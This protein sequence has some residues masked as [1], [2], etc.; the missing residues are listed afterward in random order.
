MGNKSN[1]KGKKRRMGQRRERNAENRISFPGKALNFEE[2]K[3]TYVVDRI[4]GARS[5]NRNLRAV[6]DGKG[7]RARRDRGTTREGGRNGRR[8][9]PKRRIEALK[10]D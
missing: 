1:V 6:A 8:V 4:K 7:G 9:D 3:K 2:K 10:I 5:N